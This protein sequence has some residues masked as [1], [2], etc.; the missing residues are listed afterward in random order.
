MR[1]SKL[2]DHDLTLV[3][4]V[5][6]G[7]NQLTSLPAEIGQLQQLERLSVRNSN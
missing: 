7:T 4:C 6:V 3:T 1:H 5:Q 2:T